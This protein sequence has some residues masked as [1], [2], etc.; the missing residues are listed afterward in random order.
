MFFINDYQK[1]CNQKQIKPDSTI[2]KTYSSLDQL[3]KWILDQ[4]Q[5]NFFIQSITSDIYIPVPIKTILNLK[6]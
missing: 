2:I 3:L 6:A 4:E 5:K 1:Y